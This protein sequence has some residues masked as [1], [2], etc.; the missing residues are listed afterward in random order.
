MPRNG[1]C[2]HDSSRSPRGKETKRTIKWGLRGSREVGW[3]KGSCWQERKN[4]NSQGKDPQG[5]LK[6]TARDPS[7]PEKNGKGEEPRTFEGN[8][9]GKGPKNLSRKRP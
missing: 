7:T 6:K 8:G 5:P 9:Q 1:T 4:R 2:D 3:K